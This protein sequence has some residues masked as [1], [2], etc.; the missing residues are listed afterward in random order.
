MST[1]SSRVRIATAIAAQCSDARAARAMLARSSATH[2]TNA[3]MLK[4]L[5]LLLVLS[6]ARSAAP[7]QGVKEVKTQFEALHA[8]KDHAGC[9]ALWK[10]N[11]GAVLPVIDADLEGS[12]KI[13]EGKAPDAAK[14][15][16]LHERALWG[17]AAAAE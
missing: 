1:Q 15:A 3:M 7:A 10:S 4:C 11:G 13:A 8:K 5:S 14:I 6:A 9:V 2:G 17:A 12:L 16:A